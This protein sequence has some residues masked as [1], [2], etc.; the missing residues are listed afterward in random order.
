MN[1]RAK[2]SQSFQTHKYKNFFKKC[3]LASGFV[4]KLI[5]S[6][7]LAKKGSALQTPLAV[8]TGLTLNSLGLGGSAGGLVG[9]LASPAMSLGQL[10]SGGAAF[11]MASEEDDSLVVLDVNVSLYMY[12]LRRCQSLERHFSTTY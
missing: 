12:F 5:K 10:L 11:P 4:Q 2:K 6:A 8:G 9:A 1:F 7:I 3:L